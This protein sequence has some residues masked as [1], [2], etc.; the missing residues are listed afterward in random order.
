MRAMTR[1]AVLALVTRL[2]GEA[3]L[4]RCSG[5]GKGPAL[6]WVYDGDDITERVDDTPR[7]PIVYSVH[8]EHYSPLCRRCRRDN[9][10]PGDWRQKR[11]N[12]RPT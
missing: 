1:R 8:P 3:G 9:R 11:H 2:W 7:G 12:R 6:A 10:K 4:N 5:C